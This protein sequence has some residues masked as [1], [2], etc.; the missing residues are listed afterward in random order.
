MSSTGSPAGTG[1]SAE[2]VVIAYVP[3]DDCPKKWLAN[4]EPSEA[5][6]AD[7]PSRRCPPATSSPMRRQ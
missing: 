7:G 4:A 6:S 1:T 5:R 3:N 2:A